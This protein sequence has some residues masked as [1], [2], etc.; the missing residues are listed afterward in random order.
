ME[1]EYRILKIYQFHAQ[2]VTLGGVGSNDDFSVNNSSQSKFAHSS[3]KIS[4]RKSQKIGEKNFSSSQLIMGFTHF[5]ITHFA[6]PIFL[7]TL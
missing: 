2:L 1:E 6:K 7:D 5:H 3:G 4:N